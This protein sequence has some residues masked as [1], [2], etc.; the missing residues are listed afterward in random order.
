M[1]LPLLTLKRLLE[2]E[3]KTIP[4]CNRL[5]ADIGDFIPGSGTM[6]QKDQ[7]DNLVRNDYDVLLREDGHYLPSKFLHLAPF[8]LYHLFIDFFLFRTSR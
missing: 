6:Y 7:L 1:I 5:L 4:Q 8:L 3:K 2:Q